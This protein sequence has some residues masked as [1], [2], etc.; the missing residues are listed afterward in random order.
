MRILSIALLLAISAAF[1]SCSSD[2]G[3][4]VGDENKVVPSCKI[5]AAKGFE[6]SYKDF[7]GYKELDELDPSCKNEQKNFVI[8]YDTNT[9][10][11]PD[12]N[13]L[14]FERCES[15]SFATHEE[16]IAC[17]DEITKEADIW[18][19]EH[20]KRNLPIPC[21]AYENVNSWGAWLTNDE[22]AGLIETYGVS[23]DDGTREIVDLNEDG[24]TYGNAIPPPI[25][26][27]TT[28]ITEKRCGE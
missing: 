25:A 15:V 27:N 21:V 1:L 13:K 28:P 6:D 5:V 14:L 4:V 3:N 2:E 17:K 19:N 9:F 12:I 8:I 20:Q 23:Y 16:A 10:S 11:L 24:P 7:E 18:F 22:I 26:G